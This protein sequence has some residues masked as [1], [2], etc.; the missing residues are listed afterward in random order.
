MEKVDIIMA[1]YKGA[2]YIK[3]Q[4]FSILAQT[5]TN[6]RI[7]IHDDGSSDNTIEVIKELQKIDSRILLIEDNIEF[8]NAGA[9]FLHILQYV[10]ASYIMFCDQDDIWFESKVALHLKEIQ[11]KKKPYAVYSNGYTYNGE[12]ITSEN[13]INFH[14]TH[15]K[16]SLF[17]NGGIHGCCIMF[18]KEL[19]EVFKHNLP[20]Y[21]FMHDH[22]ITM[23][24]VTFGE[25]QYLQKALMLYRQ[26]DSNVTGNVVL[27]L[28][29]RVKTFLDS[30]NPVLEKRH[31]EANRSFYYHFKN[32]LSSEQKELFTAYLSFPKIS[33]LKRVII[34]IKYQ[35]KSN[36]VF[37]LL[38]KTLIRKAI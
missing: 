7:L 22:F 11:G 21:I 27:S 33:R 35:F 31:Y 1:T 13:F 30:N 20:P 18:N 14:R 38:L 17:L 8:G 25:I 19:L 36:N 29:S 37:S 34:I 26:H 32:K 12:I 2:K 28:N 3:T 9:N 6:W 5:H 15:L 4:I 24:A 16:D 10:T 23:I